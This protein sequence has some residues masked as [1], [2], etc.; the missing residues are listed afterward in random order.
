MK[1]P[2]RKRKEQNAEEALNQNKRT[3]FSQKLG[4][5]FDPEP[6]KE[7]V[8][9]H[10]DFNAAGDMYYATVS[11]GYKVTQRILWLAFVGFM[12]I[13]IVANYRSIT[14]DNF[15]YL[16]KNIAGAAETDGNRYETLSYESD[17]RQSF[18]LYRGGM[19][20]VSP[21]KI[22]VF[23]ATGRRT[24]NDTSSFSSP[25]IES[26]GQYFLIYD[27]SGTTFSVYNSFA[28]VYTETLEY[29]IT[30]ACFADDGSFVVVTR[31][32][33]RRSVIYTYNKNMKR[34][35]E[36][37]ANYYVF[38]I[39]ASRTRDCLALLSYEAGDGTGRTVLSV[40]DFNTAGKE[41]ALEEK[42]RVELDGEFPLACG[43]LENDRFGIIT[44]SYI[45]IFDD[46]M[47]TI[48]VSDDYSHGNM[49]GFYLSEHGMAVSLT[50]ASR[51]RVIAFDKSG[52]LLYND[53]VSYH[54]SD[55]AVYGN[56]IFMQTEQGITR[57]TASDGVEESLPSGHGKMLIYNERTALVCGESKAEYLIFKNH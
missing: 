4:S 44:D 11:A 52:N 46:E 6:Q 34:S 35:G 26:S 30:N 12:V 39:V 37:H 23:S 2:F 17:S 3:A 48:E 55:I 9:R 57:M 10:E 43:F 18:A 40:R 51:N 5:F 56:S 36:I 53:A 14:Y 45:R 13:S 49:T 15:F 22:S 1:N 42:Q 24:L 38:D 28:R 16:V 50:S 8:L 25:F 20:A 32:A 27:T 47:E 19:A 7:K 33:D 41:D 21:S 31:S 54:V 29:P